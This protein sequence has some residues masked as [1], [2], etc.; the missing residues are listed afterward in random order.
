MGKDRRGWGRG[1]RREEPVQAELGELLRGSGPR[2]GGCE[3]WAEGG[4]GR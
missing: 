2:L 4:K 3:L 1:P